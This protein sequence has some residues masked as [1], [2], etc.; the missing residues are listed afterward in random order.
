MV[1][2]KQLQYLVERTS[3]FFEKYI[4][5]GKYQPGEEFTY[6]WFIAHSFDLN[7]LGVL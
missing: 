2:R 7:M 5:S 1:L 4:S 6:Q 3:R